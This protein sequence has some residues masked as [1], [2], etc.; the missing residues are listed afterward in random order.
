MKTYQLIINFDDLDDLK[1]FIKEQDN[2]SSKL[3]K[4]IK[5]TDDKRG[6]HTSS[7]HLKA[8]E[9]QSNNL[10]TPYKTCLKIVGKEMRD[11]KK[12]DIV[13]TTTNNI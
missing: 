4:T 2:E 7:L 11:N 9:Y 6:Y 12:D 13:I 1:S 5:K 3:K 8:K 10:D